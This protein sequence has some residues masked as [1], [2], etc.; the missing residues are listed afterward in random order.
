M[1]QRLMVHARAYTSNHTPGCHTA[2][3]LPAWWPHAAPSSRLENL[4][5]TQHLLL[6]GPPDSSSIQHPHVAY[7]PSH[8]I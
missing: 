4:L 1:Y 2:A 8:G 5:Q 6:L 3:C 7:K